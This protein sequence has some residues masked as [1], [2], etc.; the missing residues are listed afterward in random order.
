VGP[1]QANSAGAIDFH[2]HLSREDPNAPPFMRDLYDVDGYLVRQEEAGI[3]RS[4]LSYGLSDIEGTDDELDEAKSQHE[5]LADLAGRYP[6]RFTVFASL[7]PF[8]GDAWLAEAERALDAGFGGLCLPTSHQGRYLDSPDAQEALALADERGAVVFL[9]PSD[10]LIDPERTGDRMLTALLGRPYET[11]ICLTRLLL[12]DTLSRYPRIRI[13]V[14]QSGGVLPMVLGRVD[15]AHVAFRHRAE[16]A[17]GGPPG[18]KKPGGGGE[19]GRRMG[20]PPMPEEV[21]LKPNLDAPAPSER[22]GQ[23]F[24]DTAANHPAAVTA[25]IASVGIDHVVLGTDY[26]PLGDSPKPTIDL[27]GEMDLSAEDR[28]KILSRNA[29]QLLEQSAKPAVPSADPAT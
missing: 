7:D 10:S 14:A 6:D 17:K 8:G 13:V 21:A 12:A 2:A 15:H 9:H 16:L 25:A 4:V 29:R 23:L 20:P 5:F 24:F 1:G 27:V 11:T 19:G 18:G 26:P 28:E 22:L 3:Q